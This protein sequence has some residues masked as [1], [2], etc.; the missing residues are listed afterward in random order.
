MLQIVAARAVNGDLLLGV[1][2]NAA[3]RH[4][5]LHRTG[6]VEPGQRFFVFLDVGGLA[7]RDDFAAVN[8]GSGAKVNHVISA[9][10]RVFIMLHHDHSVAQIAQTFE[11][12]QQAI[13]VALMQTN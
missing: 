8:A 2:R 9:H 3:L 1:R 12:F 13:I 10:D 11:H 7:M 6:E 4:R 5:D